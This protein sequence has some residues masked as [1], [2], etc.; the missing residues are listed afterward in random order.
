MLINLYDLPSF[1]F[2]RKE[3]NVSA[4]LTVKKGPGRP[5]KVPKDSLPL[6]TTPD[7]IENGIIPLP[8]T[9]SVPILEGEIIRLQRVCEAEGD[10]MSDSEIDID[11]SDDDREIP[12]Q[13]VQGIVKI[14]DKSE[15]TPNPE[16]PSLIGNQEIK[17]SELD[18]SV[19]IKTNAT[20]SL[21][22][23]ESKSECDSSETDT[24]SSRECEPQQ[25]VFTFPTPLEER[26]IDLNVITDEERKVHWDFFEG[27]VSKT[28]ER[29]I[30]IRNSIVQ[31]WRR[32]KPRYLTKT[33]VRPALKN[34]GDVNCISRVHAYLELTGT[35]NFNCG[36]L[37]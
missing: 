19:E 34:C 27:R 21:C 17:N 10:S 6:V 11:C 5:R 7:V 31:E 25:P 23:S 8:M 4:T 33:S 22:E 9:K 14:E 18:A 15:E 13:R 1:F 20:T 32:V 35:I 30:K 28:P 24:K 36:K 3:K 16:T 26:I 37:F 2:C 29:Y 12:V